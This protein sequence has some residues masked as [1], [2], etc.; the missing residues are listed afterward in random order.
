MPGHL[1]VA[2][3]REEHCHHGNENRRNN[4]SMSTIAQ[5]PEYGH[6]CH[7]LN[8]DDAVE[9]Q[10]PQSVRVRL[11]RG[12]EFVAVSLL[13]NLSFLQICCS[14]L[15]AQPRPANLSTLDATGIRPCQ[16]LQFRPVFNRFNEAVW[17]NF[18]LLRNTKSSFGM[19]LRRSQTFPIF[20]P[21]T[22]GQVTKSTGRYLL[23]HALLDF[24]GN[25]AAC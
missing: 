12:P 23:V 14:S 4:V 13:K 20:L 3:A 9:N 18:N 21:C 16:T 7:R 25:A 22:L 2:D 10:V 17:P 1:A 6:R 11:R 5:N 8:H 15:Q 19:K 24:G